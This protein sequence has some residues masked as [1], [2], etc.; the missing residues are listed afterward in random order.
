LLS[1][2]A[3]SRCGLQCSLPIYFFVDS[4]PP[5]FKAKISD[6]FAILSVTGTLVEALQISAQI[7]SRF[8]VGRLMTLNLLSRGRKLSPYWKKTALLKKSDHCLSRTNIKELLCCS[9]FDPDNCQQA[10]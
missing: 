2:C 4:W 8:P 7:L 9:Y 5:F 1:V 3:W 6:V 10:N